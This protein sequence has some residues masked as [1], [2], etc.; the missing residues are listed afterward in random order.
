M[1]LIDEVAFDWASQ[2]V[3]YPPPG[4]GYFAGEVP[5]AP[6]VDCLLWRDEHGALCGVLNYF[7]L[8]YLPLERA[9]NFMV[10]VDPERRRRGIATALLAEAV[11]RWPINFEQQAYTRAGLQCVLKYVVNGG[12]DE[13]ALSLI[14]TLARVTG[15]SG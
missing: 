1:E 8:D 5:G 13:L 15:R 11:S 3:Q 14:S 6:P 10:M 12:D 4:I 7:S 2:V 9:G